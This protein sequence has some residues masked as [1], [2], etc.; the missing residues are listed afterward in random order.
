MSKKL[1]F[2]GEG[3]KAFSEGRVIELQSEK[4][5]I[6]CRLLL[7]NSDYNIVNEFAEFV[8]GAFEDAFW[9]IA[10][11][12]DKLV[13]QLIKYFEHEESE[14]EKQELKELYDVEV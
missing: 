3:I 8:V 6:F 2:K 7:E 4:G 5:V 1:V 13:N 10:C 12:D 14:E 9:D 11:N